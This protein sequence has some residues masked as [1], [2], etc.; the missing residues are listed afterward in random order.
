VGGTQNGQPLAAAEVYIPWNGVFQPIDALSTPR[1]QSIGTPL[2]LRPAVVV[3]GG[4]SGS[5]V[6]ASSEAF[7]YPTITTDKS[8]YN[9][10]QAVTITGTGWTPGETVQFGYTRSSHSGGGHNA[11]CDGRRKWKTNNQFQRDFDDV[12]VTFYVTATGQ[13]SQLQAQTSFTDSAVNFSR[14]FTTSPNPSLLG[15]L[16]T[17]S[18]QVVIAG[19]Q[20]QVTCGFVTFYADNVPIGPVINLAG[21]TQ[22]VTQSISTLGAG[23]HPLKVGYTPDTACSTNGATFGDGPA[24]QVVNTGTIG[25]TVYTDVNTNQ[26][27]D[28]PPDTPLAA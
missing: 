8:D 5:G 4:A 16:V 23:S 28:N 2:R 21:A 11:L 20:T 26:G 9:P 19:T 6:V 3:A 13:Q 10:F 14:S 1:S 15:Q 25:G 17:F 27:Y 18:T 7:T 22:P 24:T 12:G